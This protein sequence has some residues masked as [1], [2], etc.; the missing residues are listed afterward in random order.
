MKTI[1][2][3]AF[4]LLLIYHGP[5]QD[6]SSPFDA[7]WML[8]A[9]A[10][11]AAAGGQLAQAIRLP[12]LVGWIG[13][14]MLLGTG[15]LQLVDLGAFSLHQLLLLTAGLGVGFQVGLHVVWPTHAWRTLGLVAAATALVFAAVTA[16]TALLGL[17]W[18]QA[19]ILGA[20]AGLWGPFTSVPEFGR[21]GALVLAVLGTGCA[22]GML[23][24]AL[25]LLETGAAGWV[26]RVGLSL[27]AG[28]GLGLGLRLLRRFATP[29]ATIVSG[30]VGAFFFTALALDTLGLMALPCG[31]V[32]GL[33]QDKQ[34]SRRVRLLLHRG[35]PV[36]FILFFA[37]LG[38]AL[39]LGALWPPADGLYEA[40]LVLVAVP[41]LLRGLAPIAYYPLPGLH[42][43]QRIGWRLL[44]RGAL[45]FELFCGP[46]GLAPYVEAEGLLAQAVL[47]DILVSTLLFSSLSLLVD[48]SLVPAEKARPSEEDAAA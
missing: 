10:L 8:G 13:A 16:A 37:L 17:P 15:G 1:V 6:R 2:V 24:G 21:R 40:A 9:L 25:V 39:D 35:A 33:V 32:A 43:G 23:G 44:P 7:A 42:P 26:G 5:P 29:S 19:V 31:L 11:L 12:A 48:T 28:G 36:A 38:T 34:Q 22:L 3:A 30:L 46:H 27:V 14:G 4:V 20:L 41:L 47:L 45:L 18:E